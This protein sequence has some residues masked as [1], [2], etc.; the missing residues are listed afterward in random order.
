MVSK[1]SLKKKN[2]SNSNVIKVIQSF[3]VCG[4][5]T[6]KLSNGYMYYISRDG[7]SLHKTE[8]H[9]HECLNDSW[10]MKEAFVYKHSKYFPVTLKQ[11]LGLPELS[12]NYKKMITEYFS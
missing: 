10:L 11:V 2:E 7:I 12:D 9:F 5:I 3:E 8:K 1:F 6:L 4:E